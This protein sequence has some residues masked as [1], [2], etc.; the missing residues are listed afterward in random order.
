MKVF[1]IGRNYA[2]HIEELNNEVPTEPVVFIKPGTAVLSD[3]RPFYYP[4]FSNDIHYEGE[5]VF[6]IG[7]NGRAINP[8][9]ALDYIDALTVGIDF[10]ARDLQEKQ[11]QKGLPWEIAKAFD[12]AAVVGSWVKTNPERLKE[13]FLFE[14]HKNGMPVQQ[15][16]TSLWL[17]DLPKMISYISTYF[18]LQQGDLLFTGTPKGVGSIQI[19]DHFTGIFEGKTLFETE[20]R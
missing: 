20:I 12:H 3:N 2:A 7:K 10:T 9:F 16:N 6:R 18:T 4:N 14:L 15:G 11:K 8:Q 1:C 19:K 5:L 17:H 13:P